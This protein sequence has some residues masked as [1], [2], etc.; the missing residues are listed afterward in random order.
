MVEATLSGTNTAGMGVSG[1]LL[2]NPQPVTVFKNVQHTITGGGNLVLADS[3]GEF[4]ANV[5]SKKNFG[6]NADSGK[7][8]NRLK[9][10]I[11]IVYEYLLAGGGMTDYQL[12]APTIA[13]V[14]KV[15]E[16][17]EITGTASLTDLPTGTV[18]RTGL[19]LQV[20]LIDGNDA[21]PVKPDT[22][23]YT[24]WDPID[25]HLIFATN[26]D[27][28]TATPMQQGLDGGNIDIK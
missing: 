11:N 2:V 3:A 5:G 4:P 23:A 8:G 14:A 7:K 22:V 9:G 28:A 16:K 24:A 13:S 21:S 18:V 17:G 6:F 12:K 27:I 25:G 20:M 1:T 26:W 15:V 10:D 19:I